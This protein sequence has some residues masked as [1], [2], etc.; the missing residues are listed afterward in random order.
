MGEMPVVDGGRKLIRERKGAV[1]W[2]WATVTAMPGAG[3]RKGNM[4][5]GGGQG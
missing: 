3:A 4:H 5:I 2:S 1:G